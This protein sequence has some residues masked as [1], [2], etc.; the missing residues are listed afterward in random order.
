[1]ADKKQKI[2]RPTPIGKVNWFKLVNP[3]EKF[4]KYQCDLIVEDS[5]EI[6][7]LIAEVEELT[8]QAIVDAREGLTAKQA[9]KIVDSGNRPIEEE[10]LD[11]GTLT[12]RYVIKMRQKAFYTC[13]KTKEEKPFSPPRLFDAKNKEIKGQQRL[14]LSVGSGSE[15]RANIEL[16]VYANSSIGCGVSIRPLAMQLLK[17]VEY[18]GDTGGGFEAYEGGYEMEQESSFEAAPEQDSGTNEDF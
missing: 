10:E 1:M 3:D 18:L 16:S 8:K 4:K 7:K 6:Q 17:L 9:K 11:D 15:A 2:I 14:D 5:P 13:K 12:G